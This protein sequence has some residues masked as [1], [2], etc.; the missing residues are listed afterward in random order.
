MNGEIHK[1]LG[2]PV[3]KYIT[4]ERK[5]GLEIHYTLENLRTSLALG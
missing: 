3:G 4:L 2:T 1:T 5:A